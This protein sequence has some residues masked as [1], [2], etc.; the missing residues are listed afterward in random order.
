MREPGLRAGPGSPRPRARAHR[1]RTTRQAPPIPQTPRPPRRRRH[2][3]RACA[4]QPRLAG[5]GSSRSARRVPRGHDGARE[6][7]PARSHRTLVGEHQTL[8]RTAAPS[9]GA[10][11]RA[12]I[13]T[14]SNGA[15]RAAHS[16]RD[17]QRPAS[18]CADTRNRPVRQHRLAAGARAT[19]GHR[20]RTDG[21]PVLTLNTKSGRGQHAVPGDRDRVET[22]DCWMSPGALHEQ[23]Q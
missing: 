5:S 3:Q 14:A 6:Y 1:H 4:G 15:C 10:R 19:G 7:R 8:R 12:P 11:A 18:N 13:A 9:L 23:L 16:G 20:R 21:R 22:G 2:R 17:F